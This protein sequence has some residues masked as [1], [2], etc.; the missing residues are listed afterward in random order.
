MI[1]TVSQKYQNLKIAATFEQPVIP[2]TKEYSALSLVE[3]AQVVL[4]QV[5]NVILQ[6]HLPPPPPPSFGTRRDLSLN[7]F[8]SPS[9]KNFLCQVWLR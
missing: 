2:Y 7:K 4:V 3:I 5:I 9:P 6:F 8:E 1:F